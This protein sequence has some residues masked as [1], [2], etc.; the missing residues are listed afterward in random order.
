MIIRVFLLLACVLGFSSVG[1]AET[2]TLGA[3]NDWAPYANPDGTG[4]ANE[5]VS[6]AYKAVDIDVVFKVGPYNRLLKEVREGAIPGAFDVPKESANE[7]SI[8]L[9]KPRCL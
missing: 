2:I 3:E 9:V 4:M 1:F 8:Y 7:K 6:A 5:I